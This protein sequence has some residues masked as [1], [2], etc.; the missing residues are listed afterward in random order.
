[1]SESRPVRITIEGEAR[2][3]GNGYLEARFR[4]L[5][6]RGSVTVG[7]NSPNVSVE[8][9]PFYNWTKGDVT[10]YTPVP[11]GHVAVRKFDQWYVDGDPRYTDKEVS[12]LVENGTFR[13]LRYQAGEEESSDD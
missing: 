3:T 6:H 7:V 2:D 5:N 12:M 9:L 8:W 11:D 4:G 1:M 13:I 10:Q